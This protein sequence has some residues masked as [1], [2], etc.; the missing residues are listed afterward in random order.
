MKKGFVL[1][2]LLDKDL[3]ISLLISQKEYQAPLQLLRKQLLYVYGFSFFSFI[4]LFVFVSRALSKPIAQNE[5][6]IKQRLELQENELVLLEEAK[7][8]ALT[9]ARFLS[10]ISHDFR[11]P[12]NSIIG[13]SQFLDQEKLVEKEYAKLPK[14]IE[15]SGKHLLEMV[16]R[17][18]EFSH[19]ESEHFALDIKTIK[20]C[21]LLN[22]LIESIRP[23]AQ[24]KSLKLEFSCEELE[25]MSDGA[26]LKNIILNLLANAI[27]FTDKG[28]VFL[29]VKVEEERVLISIKDSGD[30]IKEE[31]REFLFKPFSRLQNA[32]NIEGSG[33][34]LALSLAYAKRLDAILS[35]K[36]H[37]IGS[38][39][40]LEMKRENI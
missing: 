17:I 18:L 24:K 2:R 20:L 10:Q 3:E 14:N 26:S 1:T 25:I 12:L 8:T 19:S 13:F 40:I 35:Y 39:F 23:L 31:E 4:F 37:S 30:G 32:K 29:S 11:T 9:K 36:N 27:K 6:L 16:N 15:K 33:L 5:R 34:G 21:D 38:E 22:E 28:Y 7:H